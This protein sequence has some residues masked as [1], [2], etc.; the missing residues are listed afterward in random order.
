MAVKKGFYFSMDALTASMILLAAVGMIMA[1]NP[2]NDQNSD[3]PDLDLLHTASIQETSQWNSS[4]NSSKTVLSHI[5][6]QHYA[7]NSTKAD[8]ICNNYFNRSKRF[9]LYMSNTTQRDK[10]CGGLKPSEEDKLIADQI[11]TPDIK[12]NNTFVGPRKAVMVVSN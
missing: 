7:G 11:I 1:H 4:I 10:I 12:I 9:A 5:Y 6:R 3:S 8:E 2:R